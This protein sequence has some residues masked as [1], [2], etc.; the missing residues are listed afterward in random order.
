MAES[1]SQSSRAAKK[2][3]PRLVLIALIVVF[4]A[5]VVMSYLWKPTGFV[6]YG[7]LIEPARPL[8][9]VAL[10]SLDGESIAL[11]GLNDKWTLLYFGP[12]V[13]SEACQNNLYNMR[14]VRL[15]QGKNA[16]R[17]QY[18]W[19]VTDAAA[20]EGALLAE[21][22]GAMV[23][24]GER[25]VVDNLLDQFDTKFGPARGLERIYLVDPIGNLMMSFAPD[26]DP[27]LMLKDLK[28]LLKVSQLGKR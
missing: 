23:L 15:A 1:H 4:S 11:D 8:Q 27:S 26:L 13:C 3:N 25:L 20:P 18:A 28:R 2:G 22:P 21:H 10:E 17:V 9:A 6:N 19:I 16:H 12:A 5:P 7:D 14:Q 24:T